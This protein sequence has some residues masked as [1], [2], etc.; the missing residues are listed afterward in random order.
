MRKRNGKR[1]LNRVTGRKRW[2]RLSD[3]SAVSAE[4]VYM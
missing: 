3:V 4:E 2:K 1:S